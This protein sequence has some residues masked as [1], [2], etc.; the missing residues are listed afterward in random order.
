MSLKQ[1]PIF[2]PD[3]D[4]DYSRWKADIDMWLLCTDLSGI[5]QGPAVYLS[6]RGRARDAV[7]GFTA[8]EVAV[9][10][11]VDKITDKLEEIFLADKTTRAFCSFKEFVDYKRGSGENFSQF[12]VEFERLYRNI[13]KYDLKL[14]EGVQAF[15]LLHAANLATDMEKLARTT[16]E[17]NFKDMRDKLMKIF[18]NVSE[19][20]GISGTPAC[21]EEVMYTEEALFA[22]DRTRGRGRRGRGGSRGGRGGRGGYRDETFGEASFSGGRIRGSGSSGGGNRYTAMGSRRET[23]NREQNP[24][25]SDGKV[26]RCH[27]CESVRHFAWNCPH[28]RNN[29]EESNLTVHHITLVNAKP[30]TAHRNLLIESLGK[31]VLDS[32]CTKTVTGNVWLEEYLST[33]SEHELS[34]VCE[35]PT[36][37]SYRFGDGVEHKSEKCVSIPVA[38]GNTAMKLD[39][40]VVPTDVPL[41][42][43]KA[44]MKQMGIKLDFQNDVANI[45]GKD[46]K[47][48]CNSSGHYCLPI[49]K[50]RTDSHEC[51]VVLY[52]HNLEGLS[53]E[54]K[55]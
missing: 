28:R 11:G 54:E 52:T 31:G 17:L 33:L 6:L 3:E 29:A 25:D 41:L 4:D 45:Y 47:L 16:A 8:A 34:D 13:V 37:A 21:K 35:K 42:I 19:S 26:M 46:I 30:D 24:T 27:E 32:G 43:S 40:E 14:P 18:G 50:Q 1:P 12:I 5:K 44:A 38:I 22:F 36:Q 23:N 2:D 10:E 53:Y 39:V 7:R 9:E 48:N 49:T 15:F 20:P 55:K 51:N